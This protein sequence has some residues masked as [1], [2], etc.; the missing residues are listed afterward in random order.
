MKWQTGQGVLVGKPKRL[1][2]GEGEHPVLDL[3]NI[4]ENSTYS[5]LLVVLHLSWTCEPGYT[6]VVYKYQ[7]L[8]VKVRVQGEVWLCRKKHEDIKMEQDYY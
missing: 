8:P 1:I 2:L 6:H 7:S 3:E 4:I 5:L